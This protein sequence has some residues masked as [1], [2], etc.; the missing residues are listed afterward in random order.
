MNEQDCI[1]ALSSRNPDRLFFDHVFFPDTQGIVDALSLDPSYSKPDITGYEV[2]TSHAD[3][4]SDTKYTK[5]LPYCH[6]FYFA[7]PI[8][9]I[10]RG[11]LDKKI[12]LI[13]CN[14]EGSCKTIKRAV[15]QPIELKPDLLLYLIL[16]RL[17]NEHTEVKALRTSF[18]KLAKIQRVKN[19]NDVSQFLDETVRIKLIEQDTEIRRLKW[20]KEI[21][22][23]AGIRSHSDL[24]TMINNI[25][26]AKLISVRNKLLAI[27][28]EL[29][30]VIGK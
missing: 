4:L 3:F 5:Y 9:V 28:H 30:M 19:E 10:H 6:Y 24:Y 17:G 13:Y 20:T 16:N 27:I 18:R 7:C 22:D 15:F 25:D 14:P 12:G 23:R 26:N 11:E 2:K 1:I 29:E 8:N 21:L